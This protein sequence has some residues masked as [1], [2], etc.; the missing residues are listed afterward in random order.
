MDW[1]TFF[2]QIIFFLDVFRIP[3]VVSIAT[4]ATSTTSTTT[5]WFSRD[6]PGPDTM[7]FVDIRLGRAW[8]QDGNDH[9]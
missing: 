2:S 3:G 4:T 9:T 5:T 1:P 6:I 7:Y 8:N